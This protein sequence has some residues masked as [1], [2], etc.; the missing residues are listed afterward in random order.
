MKKIPDYDYFIDK[1]GNVFNKNLKKLTP[2]IHT[3]GYLRVGLCKN[4]KSKDF[5][6]HRLVASCF[7]DNKNKFNEVN[8]IDSNKKNNH[9][10]NLEWCNGS[11]NHNHSLF[12][13]TKTRGEDS[14]T[15]KLKESQVLEIRNSKEP[16]SYLASK[17]GVS[18][19]T[20]YKIKNGTSWR[21]L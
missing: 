18:G 7:I 13:G 10:S 6:I 8:H 2:R 14:K 12:A 16:R 9:F 4:G 1:D 15:S 11:H 20:I 21:W 17:Y 5:Y 3:G 19:H